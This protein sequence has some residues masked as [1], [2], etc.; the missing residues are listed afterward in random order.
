MEWCKER[1]VTEPVFF[2]GKIKF[3]WYVQQICTLLLKQLKDRELWNVF[4]Q[5]DTSSAQNT[6][7]QQTLGTIF[8]DRPTIT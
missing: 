1:R 7:H 3:E 6:E 8:G 2:E 5:Q 4:F